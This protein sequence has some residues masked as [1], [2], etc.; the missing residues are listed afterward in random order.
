MNLAEKVIVVTGASDGVG[1]EVAL[2]L[3]PYKPRLALIARNEERLAETMNMALERGAMEVKTYICDLTDDEQLRR[4]VSKILSDFGSVNVLLNIAGIWQKMN[5]IEDID[6]E[7]IDRVISINLI[8]LIKLTSLIMPSLRE[9]KDAA[10]VNF[11]SRSGVTAR[12]GQ[13]IYCASKWGARGF[14]DTL[15]EDL[16]ETHIRVAGIYPAGINTKILEKTGDHVATDDY[17]EPEDIAEVIVFMLTRPQ[18][19]WLHDIRIVY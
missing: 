15:K 13:S 1:R 8:G 11:V 14:T 3:S 4:S 18:N 17:S 2:A 9:A 19:L 16:A 5:Y 12:A 7:E 10:I 6:F